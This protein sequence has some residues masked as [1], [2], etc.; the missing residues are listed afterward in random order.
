VEYE[1]IWIPGVCLIYFMPSELQ[2]PIAALIEAFWV[3]VFT[4]VHRPH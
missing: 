4:V 1:C 2:I 3:L